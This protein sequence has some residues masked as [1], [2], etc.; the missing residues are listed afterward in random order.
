MD[1]K[2]IKETSIWT[3]YDKSVM[4]ANKMGYYTTVDRCNNFYNGD[5]WEG[6]LIEGIEPVVY[7]FIKPIVNY[8]VNKITKNQRAINYSAD[9][10]YFEDDLVITKEFGK[11]TIILV[12]T[13]CK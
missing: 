10:V 11:Y 12:V 4:Y 2:E 5:Q 1:G 8:K 13:I 9:N 3:L 6:L 7:N